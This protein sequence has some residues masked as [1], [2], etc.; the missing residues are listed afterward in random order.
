[1][2]QKEVKEKIKYLR[3]L[4]SQIIL[5]EDGKK[6]FSLSKKI[7]GIIFLFLI[8]CMLF[9]LFY[10]INKNGDISKPHELLFNLLIGAEIPLGMFIMT[11]VYQINSY[12]LEKNLT[13]VLKFIETAQPLYARG[14]LN[15]EYDLKIFYEKILTDNTKPNHSVYM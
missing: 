11:D 5:Q 3:L 8:L 1:M 15:H 13:L 6:S 9:I 12:K 14:K 4:K 7:A 10:C 2:N